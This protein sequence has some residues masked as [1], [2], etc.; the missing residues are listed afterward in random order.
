MSKKLH[1]CLQNIAQWKYKVSENAVLK[2]CTL[3][4]YL[5][6]NAT[7]FYTFKSVYRSYGIPLCMW[8]K[9]SLKHF[10]AP[11]KAACNLANSPV[12]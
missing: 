5:K 4:L 6:G 11:E 12:T 3:R 10:L 8:K 1:F 9:S 2:L 7:N